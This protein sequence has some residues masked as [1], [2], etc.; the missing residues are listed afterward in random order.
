MREDV[1]EYYGKILQGSKDLKTDACCT[2]TSMPEHIKSILSGIHDE[3][4]TRYYGCGLV[5]PDH[6]LG[7][8]VL[9]LGCGAGRDCYA[10]SKL[11]GNDGSVVG[12][13][14]TE[15]QLAVA[16]KHIEYHTN[17]HGYNS[18]NIEFKKGY[19]EE[20]DKLQLEENSFDIIVS[21]CVINLSPQKD[22]VL[23]HAYNLLKPGGELYFSDVYADRRVPEELLKDPILYGECLS[24]ALYWNNFLTLAKQSGFL[25]PR[26]VEDRPISI[27]NHE[28]EKLIGH[29]NFYSATYRLFKLED[30]DPSCEDFGQA[31]KYK[32]G[33]EYSDKSLVLD[34]HHTFIKDKIS[35]VCNN[36]FRMLAETR[37]KDFFEF[38]GDTS[39][40]FGI[41]SDCGTGVPFDTV[42]E[43][44][45]IGCC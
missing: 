45:S 32:G 16:N 2:T 37:F 31:V 3:V 26:L 40:H 7:A 30:L 8:K 12:V 11:V 19:I 39:T 20:L 28:I 38:Y 13:D 15:E 42:S 44:E 10:I 21:N 24:G 23:S 36:T 5:I 1:R 33:I 27:D 22:K 14:M 17:K 34:K 41:Y 4:L 29:I 43:N 35:P 9:D 18:P 6:L 25:D